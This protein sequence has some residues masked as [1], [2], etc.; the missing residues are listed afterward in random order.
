MPNNLRHT[1]LVNFLQTRYSHSPERAREWAEDVLP[2]IDARDPLRK[3]PSD[4]AIYAGL[5]AWL[6]P[7][8]TNW[9]GAPHFVS[10]MR[11]NIVAV[12]GFMR[13]ETIAPPPA[14]PEPTLY[15]AL[16]VVLPMLRRYAEDA[17]D[18][19]AIATVVWAEGVLRDATDPEPAVV[20]L[21]VVDANSPPDAIED[22]LAA[23][24]A[25]SQFTAEME[26]LLQGLVAEVMAIAPHREFIA[27]SRAFNK[28]FP[29]PERAWPPAD[30]KHPTHCQHNPVGACC[31]PHSD[32]PHAGERA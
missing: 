28:A 29:Q 10:R 31:H 6:G 20:P 25:R 7:E 19:S 11:R 18:L 16:A 23:L 24:E 13:G 14:T 15:Q 21:E 30:C 26:A 3:P 32:C 2:L 8:W 4:A 22:R 5:D 27:L 1:V 9:E 12:L 17:G